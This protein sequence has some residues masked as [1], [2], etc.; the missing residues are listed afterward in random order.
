MSLWLKKSITMSAMQPEIQIAIGD[1]P[2]SMDTMNWPGDCGAECIFVGRTRDE[3]HPKYGKLIRLS[4]EVYEPMSLKLMQTMCEE[5]AKQFDA[6]AIRMIHSKGD[7]APG[8]GSVVIQVA[9]PHRSESF[10]A[11]KALIDRLKHELPIWKR[12]I[13]ESGETYVEGCCAHHPDD[14]KDISEHPSQGS[15]NHG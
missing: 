14:R 6:R 11:C 2:V 7:V 4:Y 8:E 15:Q 10:T 1:G 3:V 9:T 5:I 12:E 13:W